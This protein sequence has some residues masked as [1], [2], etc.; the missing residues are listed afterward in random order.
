MSE[1]YTVK[2][3]LR[4]LTKPQILEIRKEYC[5]RSPGNEDNKTHLTRSVASSIK[6]NDET[7]EAVEHMIDHNMTIENSTTVKNQIKDICSNIE[8]YGEAN[9]RTNKETNEAVFQG[10]LLQRL[11]SKINSESY[12]IEYEEIY[13]NNEGYDIS[14]TYRKIDILLKSSNKHHLIDL[15]TNGDFSRRLDQLKDFCEIAESENGKMFVL[16]IAETSSDLPENNGSVKK[17]K[18]T[19]E[20]EYPEVEIIIKG[21]DDLKYIAN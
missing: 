5:P 9:K 1:S 17:A 20:K 7:E 19:L 4:K 15:K 6:H 2:K 18:E 14:S 13:H 10:A 12:Q 16:Y 8:F 3:M 11:E 21:P